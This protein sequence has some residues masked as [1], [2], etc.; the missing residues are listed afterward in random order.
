MSARLSCWKCNQGISPGQSFL[1]ALGHTWHESCFSCRTCNTRLGTG[2]FYTVNN[3]PFCGQCHVTHD[4]PNCVKCNNPVRRGE[5]FLKYEGHSYHGRCFT[6]E[7]CNREL[8][9]SDFFKHEGRR[10]CASCSD[11]MSRSNSSSSGNSSN[12]YGSG[13]SSYGGNTSSSPS[14]GSSNSS[15]GSSNSQPRAAST[16]GGAG[17]SSYGDSNNYGATSSYGSN[18]PVSTY[19]GSSNY[20]DSNNYGSS[21][22]YGSQPDHYSVA[23]EVDE[24]RHN[25]DYTAEI[26]IGV[27]PTH[28]T[29]S[30][31]H[32]AVQHDVDDGNDANDLNALVAELESSGSDFNSKYG[33]PSTYGNANNGDESDP[34]AAALRSLQEFEG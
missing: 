2:E 9:T 33:G 32:H 26:S 14:Y 7:G 21:S 18:K 22:S 27:V 29:M 6:C 28:D 15:Y 4:V 16:Y 31:T 3:E 11:N 8:M 19:G 5:D 10:Y 30:A 25:D 34:L 12:S 23:V 20:G 17:D 13:N 1:N 24:P